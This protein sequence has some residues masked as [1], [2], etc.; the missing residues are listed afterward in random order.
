MGGAGPQAANYS[1]NYSGP[2][3]GS[4]TGLRHVNVQAL[5]VQAPPWFWRETFR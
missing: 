3:A 5:E 1:N 2:F 4:A